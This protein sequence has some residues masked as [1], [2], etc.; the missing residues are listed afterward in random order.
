MGLDA[1]QE[2][3]DR[4]FTGVQ[5][6]WREAVKVTSI[7]IMQLP[8]SSRYLSSCRRKAVPRKQKHLPYSRYMCPAQ[9]HPHC[10]HRGYL[11]RV[12]QQKKTGIEQSTQAS[13]HY[14]CY[15]RCTSV[16]P[17]DLRLTRSSRWVRVS[18][19]TSR[20]NARTFRGWT[21]VSRERRAASGTVALCQGGL[22][23]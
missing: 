6:V 5:Y 14:I 22:I 2:S 10:M 4:L 13:T 9:F 1:R 7:K 17:L 11:R 18:P 21:H 16:L 3:S 8:A 12:E 20:R 15:V 23:P 19:Y